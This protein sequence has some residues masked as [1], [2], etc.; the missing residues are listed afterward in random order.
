MHSY[1]QGEPAPVP[2]GVYI[3]VIMVLL[4][5]TVAFVYDKKAPR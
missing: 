4:L 2:S 5:V 1:A 3:G